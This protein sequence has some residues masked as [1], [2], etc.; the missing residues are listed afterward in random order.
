MF[1]SSENKE[2][3]IFDSEDFMYSMTEFVFELKKS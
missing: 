2:F 3:T 1:V